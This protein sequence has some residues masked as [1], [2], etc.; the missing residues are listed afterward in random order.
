MAQAYWQSGRTATFSLYFR[1]YP[2]DRAYFVL[3]GMDD[4]LDYLET[5]KFTEES[6]AYLKSTGIFDDGFVD[7]LGGLRFTGSVWAMPEGTVFFANETVVEVTA[8]VMEARSS[9]PTC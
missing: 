4:V 2:P 6:F 9:R 8:P 5:L 3:G 7:Y 1:S